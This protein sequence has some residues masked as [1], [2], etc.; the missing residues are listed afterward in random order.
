[1]CRQPG[2]SEEVALERTSQR[3][4]AGEPF[5]VL[6]AGAIVGVLPGDGGSYRVGNMEG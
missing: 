5:F 6:G 4:E 1:M 3:R 2:G